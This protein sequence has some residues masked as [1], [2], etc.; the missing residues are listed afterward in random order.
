M[1]MSP[2]YVCVCVYDCMVRPAVATGWPECRAV[3]VPLGEQ[4]RSI[5]TQKTY[6]RVV[7][8]LYNIA[9]LLVMIPVT[10]LLS[11]LSG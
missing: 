10:C 9:V 8:V 3:P 6:R 2:G 4:M 11:Q 1:V 5:P 7:P